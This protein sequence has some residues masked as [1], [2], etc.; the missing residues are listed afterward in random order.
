MMDL[1]VYELNS[2]I[3]RH[4]WWYVVRQRLFEQRIRKAGLG[5]DAAI[6]DIGSATGGTL[7]HLRESGFTNLTGIETSD[8][9]VQISNEFGLN[10]IRV[11]DAC[12]L[13]FLSDSFDYVLACDVIEHVDHDVAALK[14]VHRVLKT[15]HHAMIT[16]PAFPTMWSW[17]DKTYR[18]KRR[19]T[20]HLL[21][22]VISEANL[23]I[24]RLYYFNY[25][26]FL[27]VW[28]ARRVPKSGIVTIERKLTSRSPAINA[29]LKGIFM[30]D[31]KTAPWLRPP[32]G[33][34]LAAEVRKNPTNCQS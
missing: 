9:A 31:V 28:F 27:P 14:E 5:T 12:S 2:K 19:Y 7:Q 26:L 22:S 15:G 25:L 8:V 20:R 10:M 17:Q 18:H 4:H 11:G 6:L 1:R 16:V 34:S 29:L 3:E 30:L 33:V 24:I 13:P 32:F 21:R 23:E